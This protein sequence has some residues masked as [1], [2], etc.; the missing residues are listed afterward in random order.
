M[1]KLIIVLGA[2]VLLAACGSSSSSE[3]TASCDYA[4]W[5]GTIGTCLPTGWHVV[6]RQ[7]LD[8]RGVPRDVIVAFQSDTA[9]S[10]QFPTVT[11][12]REA[13]AQ[14]ITSVSYSEASVESVKSLPGFQEIDLRK[15]VIDDADLKIHIFGAQ[16]RT[17]AP[18][19]RFYQLSAASGNYG[20]TYT[21]AVPLSV[22][23][24]LENQLLLI[25][26]NVTFRK[27]T[28]K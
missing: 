6:D 5:D 23:S 28:G 12:T 18:K 3:R 2:C 7:G 9:A 11:V 20:Y 13:L 16:P 14:P 25:L 17:D 21:A 24:G 27:P 26:G 8:Q 10:G 1:K 15:Q 4:Y 22:E 19:T